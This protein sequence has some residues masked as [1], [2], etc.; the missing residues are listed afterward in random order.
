MRGGK[1]QIQPS[2]RVLLELANF[3]SQTSL[4]RGW[5]G[6]M[7]W[8]VPCTGFRIGNQREVTGGCRMPRTTNVKAVLR[9]R[10]TSK[11][12]GLQYCANERLIG[13]VAELRRTGNESRRRLRRVVG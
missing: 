10:G 11:H 12:T 7:C 5:I 9:L 1:S 6:G 4:T 2:R 3:I 8:R 13:F